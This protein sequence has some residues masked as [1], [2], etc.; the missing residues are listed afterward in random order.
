MHEILIKY[1]PRAGTN[2]VVLSAPLPLLVQEDPG[3]TNRRRDKRIYPGWGPI[4][5][6]TR[7]YTRGGD[8]SEEGQEDIPGVETNRRRDKR[9]YPGWGPIGG[10]YL[11]GL[12]LARP[13]GRL[14]LSLAAGAARGMH[15]LHTHNPPIL[16]R[17]LKSPNLCVDR[18]WTVKVYS[19]GGRR[20]PT[21]AWTATGP[22]RDVAD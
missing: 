7:G 3:E 6:G 20:A 8:Q 2:S 22:S 10:P 11:T 17:D 5:G 13:I 19:P 18:N 16:H 14:R 15:Y 12:W 4:G 1:I 9:I 21:S